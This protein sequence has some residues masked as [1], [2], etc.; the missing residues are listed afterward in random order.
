V[1]EIR[2]WE[3]REAYNTT[4]FLSWCA[5]KLQAAGKRAMVLIWDKT[6]AGTSPGRSQALAL[7]KHNRE[8]VKERE[9]ERERESGSEAG[10]RIVRC[11]LAKQSPWLNAIEPK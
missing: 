5:G 10:V 4:R 7:G 8:E 9:R 1:A 3:A 2:G 11:L 6:L